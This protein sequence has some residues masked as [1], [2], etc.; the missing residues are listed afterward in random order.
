M[1]FQH[2]RARAFCSDQRHTP[3]WKPHN[4]HHRCGG[5]VFFCVD[6]SLCADERWG[7]SNVFILW[8]RLCSKLHVK[9][10]KLEPQIDKHAFKGVCSIMTCKSICSISYT[11][12]RDAHAKNGLKI[13]ATV[14]GVETKWK[15]NEYLWVKRERKKNNITGKCYC[16]RKQQGGKVCSEYTHVL[17]LILT[18]ELCCKTGYTESDCEYESNRT[19]AAVEKNAAKIDVLRE[20]LSR[21]SHTHTYERET[22]HTGAGTTVHCLI[23]S[24]WKH[25]F[26]RHIISHSNCAWNQHFVK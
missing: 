16:S 4:H 23:Q 6:I 3:C 15:W 22:V 18:K 11:R 21:I 5:C 25:G 26:T 14:T 24:Y 20:M 13:K 12:A 19:I 17:S 9:E 7:R 8:L 2:N 10:T 1:Y